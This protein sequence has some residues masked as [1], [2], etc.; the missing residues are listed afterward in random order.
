MRKQ[1]ATADQ[2]LRGEKNP[3]RADNRPSEVNLGRVPKVGVT[4]R[5]SGASGCLWQLMRALEHYGIQVVYAGAEM[6]CDRVKAR[7]QNAR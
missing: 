4:I 1:K 3:Q 2:M 5:S 6:S 7:T